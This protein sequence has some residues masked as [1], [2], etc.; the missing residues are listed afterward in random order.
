MTDT[1]E[2]P[3]DRL[4]TPPGLTTLLVVAVGGACGALLRHGIDVTFPVGALAFPWPTLVVNVTGSGA[5]AGLAVLPAVREQPLLAALV[6]PGLVGG[7]TTF[8]A[9]A[10]QTRR[11]LDGGQPMVALC[12][13]LGTLLGCLLGCLAGRGGATALVRR[14]NHASGPAA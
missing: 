5:L 12:Y 6:G 10:E 9:Y 4:F 7:Y 13:L 8:S 2:G 1:S 11:L 14:R 3:G